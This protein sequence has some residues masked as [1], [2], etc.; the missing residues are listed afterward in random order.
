MKEI[1]MHLQRIKTEVKNLF[2]ENHRIR[3]KSSRNN[4][5]IMLYDIRLNIQ[6]F[7]KLKFRWL[8]FFRFFQI[9]SQKDTY[10]IAELNDA[11]LR[12]TTFNNRVKNSIFENKLFS[13]VRRKL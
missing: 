4:D 7:E 10:I 8:K 11:E 2:D 1:I 13:K 6:H 3:T 9:F 12:K 5:M